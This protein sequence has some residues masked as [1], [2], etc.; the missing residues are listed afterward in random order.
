[1]SDAS[2]LFDQAVAASGLNPVIAPFTVSRLLLR[3][4][5][6]PKQ[7]TPEGLA[8]ALPALEEGLGVYLRGE[9]LER[10]LRALRELAGA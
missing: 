5:V 4:D 7:L 10:S 9:D 8:R 6:Q 2:T 3:V 1:M